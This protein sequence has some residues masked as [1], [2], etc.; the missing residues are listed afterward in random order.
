MI[1]QSAVSQALKGSGNDSLGRVREA[2]AAL[3]LNTRELQEL[4]MS[5]RMV[6]MGSVFARFPR[7]VR[8]LK[9]LGKEVELELEGEGTEID[10]EMI[11][12]LIDPL[13]HLIRNAVDHG[14]EPPELRLRA[15]KPERGAGEARRSTRGA[16]S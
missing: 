4:V 12:Q 11:E 14:I 1:S 8:D 15:G 6:P 10:K 2:M 13:T 5:V 9:K 3:E 16:A 7:L